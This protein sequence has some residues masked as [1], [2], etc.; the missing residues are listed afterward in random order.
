MELNTIGIL[1]LGTPHHGSNLAKWGIFMGK[2]AKFVVSRTNGKI[3]RA[4]EPQSE[5]LKVIQE[6]F[7]NLVDRRRDEGNRLEPICFYEEL[8]YSRD[9]GYVR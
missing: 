6:D 5:M 8:P 2:M 3:L 7:Q 4:M 9:I 1:F